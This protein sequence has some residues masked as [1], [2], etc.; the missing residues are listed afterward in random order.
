MNSHRLL[1]SLCLAAVL[2]SPLAATA[3]PNLD[4]ARQLNQAF[5]EL[6]EKVS[7]SVVVITVTQKPGAVAL[8]TTDTDE[9]GFTP[10]EFYRHFHQQFEDMPMEKLIGQGSGV[11]I[12][13]DGFILTNRH[14]VEDAVKIEVRLKDG[15]TFK[16]TVRGV[17]PQ[18][19]VAVIK[20]EAKNLPAAKFANSAKTRVGE[21]AI[22]IGAPFSLDYSVTFGHVSAKGRSNIVPGYAGGALLDQDFIQTDANIN[23]GNSGGPLVNIDGEI[24]GIN[25]LIRGLRTGIGFAIPSNLAREVSDKLIADGKFT[26]AWLGVYIRGLKE[27][28]NYEQL[29]KDVDDGVMVFGITADGP[30]AKSDLKTGDVVR[31]VDGHRVTSAQEMRNEIRGKKIGQPVSLEVVRN[32]KTLKLAVKPGEYVDP[33]ETLVAKRQKE[34]EP[35]TARLGLKVQWFTQ[36]EADKFKVKLTD[37]VIITGVDKNS[38]AAKRGLKPGDIITSVNRERT[39]SPAQVREALHNADL[40]KGVELQLVSGGASRAETLKVSE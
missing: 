14:V 1:P 28:P 7:P 25:T 11:I 36:E 33:V 5:V 40:K 4:L 3:S 9:E 8:D 24:I 30:A 17:D 34:N 22:A 26:R 23:P 6:A 13:E 2:T 39:T 10:R 21:F 15:R 35:P 38:P 31:T 16:A 18:S 19:D 37:G 12:R 27:D 29:R 20:I 32:G